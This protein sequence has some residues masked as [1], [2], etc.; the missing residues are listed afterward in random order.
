MKAWP[1]VALAD[2]AAIE[3][4]AVQPEAIEDDTIYVGLENIETGGAFSEVG[5]VDAGA[6]AS[7]K[8]RFSQRH[9]LYGK[10]RPYLA[11]IACPDFSGI[12]STDILPILPGPKMD[13]RYFFHYLR[14]PSMV[15]YA[16]SR[17][18]GAN[19]PRL[20]P[21]VLETFQVPLPPIPDQRRIA[22]VLDRAEALRAKRRAALAQLDAL[23]Q[24]IFLD[25]FGDPAANPKG[26]P[27]VPFG[28]L[29]TKIDSGWSPICLD[30]PVTGNEWGILKLGAVTWCEYNPAENKAML[31]DVAPDPELQIQPGDLLFTRKNTYELVAA[32]ALVQTTPPR[33][34]MSDLI[35]RFRLLPDADMDAC[36]LHR[37]LIYPTKR[38]EIQKL[39]GGSAGSM[40]NISKARLQ[41]ALI[42]VPPLRV[43]RDFA[44]RVAG[45]EKLKSAY[46]ASLARLDALFAVLQYRA[47]RGEL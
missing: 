31:P 36:F 35:F 28:E 11:K 10:L 29:L 9:V 17:A 34:Q 7:S 26:W 30:R 38:R 1:T 37:L 13:R 33:L 40:P 5:K 25:L 16:N 42:E 6:L 45:V 18:V 32:C 8:F 39:A 47:F 14:Q 23:T 27:R 15:E 12:C 4:D 21:S 20:G 44:R 3:R 22:E 24:A 2:V 41:S 19:L 43:Q 46:R